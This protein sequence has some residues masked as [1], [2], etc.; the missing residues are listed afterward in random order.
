MHVVEST[1]LAMGTWG[2]LLRSTDAGQ[3][4]NTETFD[5]LDLYSADLHPS[6]MGLLV[7][8]ACTAPLDF[9]AT[10]GTIRIGTWHTA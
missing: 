4:W 5:L 2:T 8:R 7:G 10:W 3:T 9:G 6:G 1:V